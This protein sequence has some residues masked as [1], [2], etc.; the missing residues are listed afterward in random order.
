MQL[1][2]RQLDRRGHPRLR[3]R[4]SGAVVVGVIG[5]VASAAFQSDVWRIL[6]RP[7]RPPSDFQY[8]SKTDGVVSGTPFSVAPKT[9]KFHQH[10]RCVFRVAVPEYDRV[11]FSFFQP[12]APIASTA[13]LSRSTEG[14]F[15]ALRIYRMHSSYLRLSFVVSSF[16]ANF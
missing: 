9:A 12:L 15:L 1:K 8:A 4:R 6:R 16:F 11:I 10:F 2:R 3:V 14:G 7:L 13:I 5:Y